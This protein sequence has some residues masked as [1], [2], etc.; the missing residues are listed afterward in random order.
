MHESYKIHASTFIF[1]PP[2]FSKI[3]NL[4]LTQTNSLNTMKKKLLKILLKKLSLFSIILFF[5]GITL[6]GQNVQFPREVISSGGGN[7][8]SGS[9]NLT[10]WRIGQI[11]V[12]TIPTGEDRL[13]QGTVVATAISENPV[14]DWTVNVYPNP[15][16]TLLNIRFDIESPGE[17]T[18][19]LYDVRGSKIITQNDLTILP[20]Q[21][22]K[23]DLTGLTPALYLLKIIPAAQGTQKLFK[24]TKQ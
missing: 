10:R 22:A 6:L 2:A 17:F 14:E 1:N 8:S 5:S 4:A 18:L 19:E 9:V 20:G 21:V 13:K 24:I 11:N 16:N 3:M 23:I 7:S 12:V 15:V